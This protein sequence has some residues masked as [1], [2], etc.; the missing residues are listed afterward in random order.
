MS[1]NSP[2]IAVLLVASLV[3]VGCGSAD[4]PAD[5]T[6]RTTAS[7]TTATNDAEPGVDVNPVAEPGRVALARGHDLDVL[8][9]AYAPVTSRASFLIAAETLRRDAIADEASAETIAERAGAVRLEIRRSAV[10]LAAARRKV[11]AQG[12]PT[13]TAR[14][15]QGL[16]L[17]AIGARSR[18]LT[19][20]KSLLDADGESATTDA[21]RKV[22][23]AAWRASWDASVR[24]ARQATTTMQDAR[25][26][27]GLDPGL[28]DSIR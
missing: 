14:R 16:L 2:L 6:A 23:R 7:T 12:T 17:A 11:A 20:L 4:R 13:P 3:L 10:T 28:E 25:A 19:E 27:A 9:G 8:V 22:L 15:L 26:S 24:A 18:A 5:R 1:R 21:R